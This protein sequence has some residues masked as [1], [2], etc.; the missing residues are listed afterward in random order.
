M[1]QQYQRERKEEVSAA[2]VNR[3]LACLKAIFN[4][5]IEWN[6]VESNPVQKVKFFKEN[7]TRLDYLTKEE[8][9]QLIEACD[10]HLKSIVITAIYTG[11]RRAVGGGADG[12]GA[13]H[14]N[15]RQ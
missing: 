4:K 7:N 5:A 10:D 3:E 14:S 1:V 6:S 2:S 9:V 12:R 15:G 11:M 8:I 13:P